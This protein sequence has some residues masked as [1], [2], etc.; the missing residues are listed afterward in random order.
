LSLLAVGGLAI[1]SAYAIGGLALAPHIIGG[2]G[3]DPEFVRLIENLFP[4]SGFR[5]G[6]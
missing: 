1:S 4:G 5:P 3:I 6:E 2:N